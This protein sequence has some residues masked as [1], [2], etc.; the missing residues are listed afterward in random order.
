MSPSGSHCVV[1]GDGASGTV[2]WTR[3]FSRGTKV[4]H[5]SEHSDLALDADGNDIYV[6]VDY[7]SDAG[8][9]FM[10]VSA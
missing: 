7:Q 9:L 10:P 1:S 8:D 5:K 3:D 6:S 2:A 4:H